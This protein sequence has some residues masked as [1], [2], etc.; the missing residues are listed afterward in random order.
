MSTLHEEQHSDNE[1]DG[2]GDVTQATP[3]RQSETSKTSQKEEPESESSQVR[4]AYFNF[5]GGKVIFHLK[6]RISPLN[7]ND[8]KTS[9][10]IL[11]R[12]MTTPFFGVAWQSNERTNEWT[13]GSGVTS[14]VIFKTLNVVACLLL[15]I[16]VVLFCNNDFGE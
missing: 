15:L 13:N 3:E 8:E 2:K 11:N 10:S 9:F 16:V 12:F 1:D 7:L 6:L 14:T 4:R 5:Y